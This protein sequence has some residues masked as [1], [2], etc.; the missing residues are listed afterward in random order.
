MTDRGN[1]KPGLAVWKAIAIGLVWVN[2]PVLPIMLG[3]WF[4]PLLLAY[5]PD[6]TVPIGDSFVIGLLVSGLLAGFA[7]AWLWWSVTVPRWR[8]WAYRRVDDIAK[9]KSWAVTVGLTWPDG[10]IFERTEI[11]SKAHGARERELEERGR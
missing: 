10:H 6:D 1:S 3:V 4:V 7:L 11:K 2:G 9:L 5:G 8:L